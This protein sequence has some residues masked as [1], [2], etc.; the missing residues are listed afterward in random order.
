[1]VILSEASI[2]F[3]AGVVAQPPFAGRGVLEVS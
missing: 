3:E 1:M 2:E